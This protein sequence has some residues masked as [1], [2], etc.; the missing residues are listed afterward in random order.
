M[1]F[2]HGAKLAFFLLFQVSNVFRHWGMGFPLT[3]A[4]VF[5]QHVWRVLFIRDAYLPDCRLWCSPSVVQQFRI[6]RSQKLHW[7]WRSCYLSKLLYDCLLHLIFVAYLI[8][9]L[10][11]RNFW[12]KTDDANPQDDI[13][14]FAATGTCRIL[15]V[16]FTA[17]L[18]QI[19]QSSLAFKK[20][21]S[22]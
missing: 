18:P 16:F 2:I 9:G 5:V 15:C 22:I 11:A 8:Q 20:L 13:Q 3:L 6:K 14:G 19:M 10:D 7:R 4:L 12:W 17:L 1:F 21:R